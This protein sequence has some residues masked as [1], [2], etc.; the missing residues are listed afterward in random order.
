MRT[1]SSIIISSF[2]EQGEEPPVHPRIT[3]ARSR[4]LS[5]AC[6]W[7][8]LSRAQLPPSSTL[9]WLGATR[10]TEAFHQ[11]QLPYFEPQ[12]ALI[13]SVWGPLAALTAYQLPLWLRP[14]S[15]GQSL[16]VR[17]IQLLWCQVRPLTA[18]WY[19]FMTTLLT[20][21]L[22]VLAGSVSLDHL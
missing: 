1:S 12:L 21:K 20:Q 19:D 17:S 3:C 5:V 18:Q 15:H 16:S 8:A 4:Q 13:H 22:H 2:N 6:P 10:S 14:P 9:H 11:D 7:G